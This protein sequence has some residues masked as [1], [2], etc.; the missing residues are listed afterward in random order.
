[1]GYFFSMPFF[2]VALPSY[3]PN[4]LPNFGED[5]PAIY[6]PAQQRVDRVLSGTFIE[7]YENYLQM[8]DGKVY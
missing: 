1:M 5:T 2:T 8:S 4:Q 3:N 6:T 7:V